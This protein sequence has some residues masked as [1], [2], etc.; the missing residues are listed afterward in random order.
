MTKSQHTPTPW[1]HFIHD[2]NHMVINDH[3]YVIAEIE[4]D[5][6]SA[7]ME[8]NAA[9]IVKAVNEREGL[10]ELA[11]AILGFEIATPKDYKT[12]GAD[13]FSPLQK[14]IIDVQNKARAALAKAEAE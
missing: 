13:A 11:R 10:I 4:P 14:H 12:K 2:D 9:L 7:V 3:E 1:R 6:K 5:S 8:A